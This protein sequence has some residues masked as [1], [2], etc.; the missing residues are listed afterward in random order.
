MKKQMIEDMKKWQAYRDEPPK[1]AT[2]VSQSGA[3]L[4]VERCRGSQAI[5][6]ND[7]QQ[8]VANVR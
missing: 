6:A 4:D 1:A 7:R 8:I 5:R 2:N 3:R